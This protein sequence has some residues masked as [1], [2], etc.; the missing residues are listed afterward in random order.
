[1]LRV[2]EYNQMLG[3]DRDG[4]VKK[5]VLLFWR[6]GIC[7]MMFDVCDQEEEAKLYLQSLGGF[8]KD[9]GLLA[10]ERSFHIALRTILNT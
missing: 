3:E 8:A 9:M 10:A 5:N 7:L 4:V 1:M 6:P 2:S